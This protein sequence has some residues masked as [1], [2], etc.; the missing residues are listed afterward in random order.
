MSELT[1]SKVNRQFRSL[2]SKCASLTSLSLAPSRPKVAVTYGSSSRNATREHQD[3][4]PPL[5]ILQSLDKLGSR[6]HFDRAIVE[7]MQLSKRIY[8]VRDAFKNIV[9]STSGLPKPDTSRILPLAGICARVVGEHVEV[10]MK[11]SLEGLS[12]DEG[13]QDEIRSQI[14]DELYEQVPSQ[15]RK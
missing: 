2:R 7:N 12:D 11:A 15:Y 9:Q 8:E 1:T 3:D 6:L 4:T 13:G 5:A 10:E 14:M